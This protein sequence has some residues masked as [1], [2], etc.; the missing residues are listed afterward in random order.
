MGQGV[1]AGIWPSINGTLI[2]AL[3]LV[4]GQMGWDEWKK[5]SL[6][7][8]AENFPEVWYGIWS[9]PDTYNSDLSKYPGQTVF[10]ED[11]ISG[12]EEL[13]D[14]EEILGQV[15]T[16]WTDFPVFNLHPHAWPLYDLTRLFGINFTSEG[17]ELR[18]TIPQDNYKFVSSLI[19]IEKSVSGYSGWYNPMKE[20]EWKLI[21]ILP[22][23]EVEKID[24][25]LN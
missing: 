16:A 8:H 2:W 19:G 20:G 12:K 22:N 1:N 21:V 11:L 17:V 4:D 14:G 3:S 13:T 24:S 7:Y 6:A 25:R 5:N 18:P 10:D 9:G 15:A 23:K